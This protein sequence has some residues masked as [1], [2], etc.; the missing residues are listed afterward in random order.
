MA[1]GSGKVSVMY[2]LADGAVAA[3][4]TALGTFWGAV[5]GALDNSVQWSVRGEGIEIDDATGTLVDSWAEASAKTGQGAGNDNPVPDAAQVLVRWRTS[6]VVNGRFLVGRQFIPGLGALNSTDGNVGGTSI[7]IVQNAANAL[8]ASGTG[9]VVWHRP[10]PS[11]TGSSTAVSTA[12]VWSE[13]AVLRK[14]R[15]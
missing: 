12:S 6:S 10:G 4:R 2:F 11:G 7:T 15:G 3:Q 1:S 5:D 14:R 8:I 13:L 9:L